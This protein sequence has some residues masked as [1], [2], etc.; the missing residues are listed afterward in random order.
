M[1]AGCRGARS[2]PGSVRSCQVSRVVRR[3]PRPSLQTRLVNRTE[4]ALT[5]L[6]CEPLR[7][8]DGA[9]AVSFG[10][11]KL[12]ERSRRRGAPAGRNAQSRA[13][14]AAALAALPS[15]QDSMRLSSEH[16][17][18]GIWPVYA[19]AERMSG[20]CEGT[21]GGA[22]PLVPCDT[23]SLQPSPDFRPAQS[24]TWREQIVEPTHA[25]RA[26]PRTP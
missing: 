2:G 18:P 3:L 17:L 11:R 10:E 7:C 19:A 15:G 1:A 21:D 24:S 14:A 16:V 4:C 9:V 6:L 5:K 20:S 12:S 26:Q 22:A 25:H 8:A 23:S 13:A